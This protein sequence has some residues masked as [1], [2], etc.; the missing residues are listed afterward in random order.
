[1]SLGRLRSPTG[2]AGSTVGRRLAVALMAAAFVRDGSAS[3]ATDG[4][5]QPLPGLREEV[6]LSGA[7][8]KDSRLDLN[9]F[10][11][12]RSPA[13]LLEEIRALWEQRPAPV[14][15]FSRDGW[16]VLVQAVG[17]AV[18]IIEVRGRGAGAE[19][20][21]SR[22]R[23]VDAEVAAS[24]YWLQE[25]LPAGSRVL[26]RVTHL[27]GGRRMTTL[28]AVVSSP[29]AVVSQEV[30]GALARHGFARR[31]RGT[32]SMVGP[33]GVVQFLA[34]ESKEGGRS[35]NKE[36]HEMGEEDL[37]LTVTEQRGQSAVVLH[38]SRAHR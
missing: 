28:V 32:P 27:D 21:R 8:V 13:A 17:D 7:I 10:T 30:L 36:R 3:A 24:A 6:V 38:W 35:G 31:P 2:H 14:H 34:R 16:Q 20:R 25:V 18:E 33:A 15:G 9:R 19:G 37:A 26:D 23:R 11:D 22:L 12:P 29:V 5:L 4:M 1:M